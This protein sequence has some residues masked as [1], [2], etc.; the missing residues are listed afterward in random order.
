MIP[1]SI[2]K[3]MRSV[4]MALAVAATL[5]CPVRAEFVTV[6]DLSDIVLWAGAGAG[7]N[8]AGFVLQFGDSQAP[9]SIAWGYRWNAP[10]TPTVADMMFA[11]AGS[12]TI[13]GGSSPPPGLDSRLSVNGAQYNFGGG[14]VVFLSSLSYSQVGLP[15]EWFQ[16]SRQIIDNYFNDGTYPAFYGNAG[17]NGSWDNSFQASLVGISE[18]VLVPGGW[19]GFV[20]ADG[21][22]DPFLFSQPVSAVAVPEPGTWVL[23]VSAVVAGLMICRRA[24]G[25]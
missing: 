10:A 18:T 24:R 17:A 13:S 12:T 23:G 20:Q 2:F 22:A 19:Y 1:M 21:S 25:T 14:P 8:E 5:A 7:A 9:T 11:I 4:A 15:P 3:A 16:G 6:S